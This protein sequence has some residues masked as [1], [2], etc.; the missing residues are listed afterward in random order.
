MYV[1]RKWIPMF[2]LIA[3]CSWMLAACGNQAAQQGTSSQPSLVSPSASAAP[4]GSPEERIIKHLSGETRITG[5][6][7]RVVVMEYGLLASVLA[8]DVT[9]VG[10]TDDGKK[11]ILE[12]LGFLQKLGA[13]TP[14]GTRQQPNLELIRTLK[15]DL[16]I[17]DYAR[18]KE[19]YGELA[20][21]APT[22]MLPDTKATYEDVISNQLLIGTALNQST[23]A[24]AYVAAHEAKLKAI[25]AK[26]P[27][28]RTYLIASLGD[29]V[30]NPR[31][32]RFF[33]PSMLQK[34]G[35][36]YALKGKTPEETAVKANIEQMLE[37]DPDIMF[38]TNEQFLAEWSKD[39]L[40]QQLK[41]VQNKQLFPVAHSKWSFN[42]SVYAGNAVLDEIEAL[43]PQLK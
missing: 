23:A 29:K 15:P 11:D 19:I 8:L 25:T 43:L 37:I 26:M 9:P 28:N 16:I 5:T 41:A 6:P 30:I 7:Q 3:L 39:P 35:L 31:T 13:Y 17:G 24:A 18:H 10:Y 32:D 27:K 40:F 42:R 22:L 38:V 34:S 1:W 36:T 21:I 4:S 14:V 33:Q 12:E 2:A 20:K